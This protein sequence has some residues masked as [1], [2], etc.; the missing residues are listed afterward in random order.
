MG[1][2]MTAPSKN[3]PIFIP[4][5]PQVSLCVM[6][7]WLRDWEYHKDRLDV[8]R[9][10]LNTMLAGMPKE[11]SY[12]LIVWDNGSDLELRE[13]L[14]REFKISILAESNLN[15]GCRWG[16]YNMASLARG[17]ILYISD[18]DVF[19]YPNWFERHVEILQTFP[20][21]GSV[22]GEP[23]RQLF[24]F[25]NESTKRWAIASE[26]CD[27]EAGNLIPDVYLRDY[28]FSVGMPE[29]NSPSIVNEQ[30]ILLT[31]HGVK[32]W[33]HGHHMQ[34]L[35]YKDRVITEME[36]AANYAKYVLDDSKPFER[37]VDQQGW[38]RLTT[39]ERTVRHIGNY[40][41]EGIWKAFEESQHGT[42]ES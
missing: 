1:R 2:S 34:F 9:M 39:Y 11:I 7:H 5:R 24:R 26:G 37:A 27:V 17:E 35:C 29:G 21:V 31:Y 16:W 6:T 18:D 40:I 20:D 3:F 32:A 30:D 42:K 4:P 36:M 25:P 13:I 28:D 19:H 12:E 15:L 38:L 41:D 10:T 8:I 33:A 22:S 23:I 14:R